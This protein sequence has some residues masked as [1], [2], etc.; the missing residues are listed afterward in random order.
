MNKLPRLGALNKLT[1]EYVLPYIANK[2]DEHICPDCNK[3]LILKKGTKRV[4]HFAHYSDIDPCNYYNKPTESQIHKDAKFLLKWLLEKKVSITFTRKCNREGE[5]DEFTIPVIT[6]TSLIKLE[7]RFNYN[8]ALKIADVAYLNNNEVAYIFEICNT[9]KTNEDDRP[10]PWFE[11]DALKLVMTVNQI[12]TQPT[13]LKIECI[14]DVNCS[15]CKKFQDLDSK[16]LVELKSNQQDLEW[17]IRYKTGQRIFIDSE[18]LEYFKINKNI[19]KN[20]WH[21]RFDFDSRDKS[22]IDNDN[23]KIF[24]LFNKFYSDK[25]VLVRSWKGGISFFITS[26]S[27]T[28]K[29]TYDTLYSSK[30][31]LNDH[32]GQGTIYIIKDILNNIPILDHISAS[33]N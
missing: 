29:Y 3:D 31:A 13:E 21:L 10:E 17:Y 24:E 33:A 7:H 6:E 9:H 16:N 5:I 12:M 20:K 25:K 1:N 2:Q 28:R 8:N 32:N 14:R 22:H 19:N 11:I 4:H 18:D 23:Q 27:N 15:M 30:K 26:K